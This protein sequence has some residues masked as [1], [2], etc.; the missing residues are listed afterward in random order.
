M[1]DPAGPENSVRVRGRWVVLLL[2]ASLLVN[3]FFLAT[4]FGH[5][6]RGH[7][8]ARCGKDDG[9]RE[10]LRG[11]AE[12]RELAKRLRRELRVENRAAT[13]E[14]R[15]TLHAAQDEFAAAMGATPFDA[16]RFA[17]AQTAYNEARAAMRSPRLEWLRRLAEKLTPEQRV[18]LAAL[19]TEKTQCRKAYW[20]RRIERFEKSLKER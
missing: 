17:A 16:E 10:F 18:R 20:D 1:S 5:K 13:Q 15:K 3:I 6:I 11:D 8:R 9:V 19:F 12:V 2:I 4:V 7:D 14:K